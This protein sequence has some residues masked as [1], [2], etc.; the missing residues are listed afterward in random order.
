[1]VVFFHPFL[2]MGQKVKKGSVEQYM[3]LMQLQP[4]IHWYCK[5]VSEAPEP[6]VQ[7]D[8]PTWLVVDTA[9]G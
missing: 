2:F 1:M 3:E 9:I 4:H 7:Y 6:N 8:T 5:Y